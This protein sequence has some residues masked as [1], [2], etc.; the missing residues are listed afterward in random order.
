MSEL[1][2]VAPEALP[3]WAP[4][5]FAQE[6]SGQSFDAERALYHS[7][8]LKVSGCHFGGPVD[9][10]SALKESSNFLVEDSTFAMRY[11]MWH[12]RNFIMRGCTFNE[13]TRAPLWYDEH[14]LIENCQLHSV[15]NI[16]ECHDIIL[17][18]CDIDSEEF[19]W[20]SSDIVMTDCR[21]NSVYAFLEAKNLTLKKVTATG[22]YA[23]QYVENALIEDS[24]IET[25]D[26]LWH[27]KNVTVKNCTINTEY[28]AWY[29]DGLTLINCHIKS[30]QPLCY[31]KNL[32]LID[33]TMEH[34]DRAFE[35][36]DITATIKGHVDSIKNPL[37]GSIRCDS[38]GE[39]I[40][41]EP[42]RPCHCEV[43]V[44]G[45]KLL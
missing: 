11:V 8:S 37:S 31:C 1:V 7:D 44:A 16:R 43:Y 5:S 26:L 20:K 32:K 23:F 36:S 42:V 33:C 27:A 18:G 25:K 38:L 28:F 21:L 3:Q 10:E 34:A 45:S 39:L 35:Y 24:S 12:D 40:T 6:L 41:S 30:L 29:S 4:Q 17:R 19:G 2:Q 13:E 14:G 9:G 22:K 15:K